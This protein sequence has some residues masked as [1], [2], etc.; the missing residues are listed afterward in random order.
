VVI[1]AFT[2]SHAPLEYSAGLPTRH[3]AQPSHHDL[4]NH[5]SKHLL[6]SR[7]PPTDRSS[8]D[9]SLYG[10]K[11][12]NGEDMRSHA[13]EKKPATLFTRSSAAARFEAQNTSFQ[14]PKR[15]NGSHFGLLSGRSTIW[16]WNRLHL[17]LHAPPR[18]GNAPPASPTRKHVS[19]CA[20]H[21]PM[22][23]WHTPSATCLSTVSPRQHATS[24]CHVAEKKKK[25]KEEKIGKMERGFLRSKFILKAFMASPRS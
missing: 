1:R 2:R 10:G 9:L 8:S 3:H 19:A 22:H 12:S 23:G 24:S 11:N 4:R 15:H 21:T 14:A 6:G 5:S 13:L 25:K 7:P 18:A 16:R 17:R 20:R